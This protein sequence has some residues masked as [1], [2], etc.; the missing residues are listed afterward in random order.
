MSA[1]KKARSGSSPA[2]LPKILFGTSALGNLFCEP[3]PEEKKAVVEQI[4]KVM[5]T[6]LFDSAGKYGAGLALEELGRCLEELGVAPDNVLISNKLGWKRVPLTTPEP[7]FEPGAWVNLKNDAVQAISYE[8]ILECYK[9][10]N[11]LLGKYE[12]RIVSVHDPD[13][14]L[15]AATGAD[16]LAKRTSDVL[17]AYKALNELKAAG[18]VDSIGVGAK[19]IKVIELIVDNGIHLDWAMFACSITPYTH[20]EYARGLLSKLGAKGITVINSAVFNAGFLIGGD[21]FDYRKITKEEEPEKFIWRDKFTAACKD[22]NVPPAAVCVQ[23]S[24]LFPEITSVALNTTQPKRVQSNW[25]LTTTVIPLALW[26]RLKNEGLVAVGPKV[27]V[28]HSVMFKLI[29]EATDTQVEG[30]VEA[31]K[32]MPYKIPQM[33]SIVCGRDK[34]LAAQGN[35]DFALTVDF[36]DAEGYQVYAAHPE[37]QRVIAEYI[38][39]IILPGSRVAVQFGLPQSSL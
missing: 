27:T 28:R 14:Y 32:G 12:S 9:Q 23:F 16:D 20:T 2:P 4:L 35:H 34:G 39:P 21:H 19:D 11:E 30:M 10:G 36:A 26:T 7:T 3:K 13:E 29:P 31:L 18:K 33:A 37:H 38:K 24:F 15:G 22:Y 1:A 6:P 5:P 25:D 8:G 17:G